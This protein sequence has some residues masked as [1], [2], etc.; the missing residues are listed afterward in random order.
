MRICSDY[1]LMDKLTAGPLALI[2]FWKGGLVR[3]IRLNFAKD[4]DKPEINSEQGRQMQA[5]LERMV[6]GKPALWPDL[7]LDFNSVSEFSRKVIKAMLD[8]EHGHFLTYGEVAE[9]IGSPKA[10]RAVGRA[11]GANP[12]PVY[13]P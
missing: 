5:G 2:M 3:G 1:D 11:V 6:S 4:G 12:W 13:V 10:S 7:P 9:A 8:I